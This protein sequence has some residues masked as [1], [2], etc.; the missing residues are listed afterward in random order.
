[1]IFFN[2]NQ[3]ALNITAEN[4]IDILSVTNLKLINYRNYPHINL[5]FSNQP[6]I[7]TGANGVGKTNIL[8]AISLLSPGRGLRNIKLEEI[9]RQDKD[10]KTKHNWQ[11]KAFIN[12]VYGPMEVVTSSNID[13]DDKSTKRYIK[14]NDQNIKNQSELAKIFSIIWL[15]PQMDQLFIGSSLNRRRFIDRLVFNFDAEHAARIGKYENLMRERV[16]LLKKSY[17][18]NIWLN[19]VE[20]N[21]AEVAVAIAA[22]RVQIIEYLQAMINVSTGAFPKAKIS[23]KGELEE[24]VVNMPSLQLEEEFKQKLKSYRET[25]FF[26]GRTNAGIHRSDLLVYHLHKNI[27]ASNCST[28]EQ[29]ALLLSIILAEAKARIK[30]RSSTPVLL[31][32]EVIAHLDEDRRYA[33]FEELLAM[34]AQCWITGTD[35]SIFDSLINHAQFIEL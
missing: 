29:K 33:L 7:I 18:D 21:M 4:S 34:Q 26:T 24:K 28:G 35:K 15:T 13:E 25:D 22:S 11:I 5:N 1:V 32:D 23:M 30:W 10:S 19:A 31:L 2:K 16:K 6:V 9:G 17:Q 3:M 12:S 20:Q 14:I 27:E 8:E